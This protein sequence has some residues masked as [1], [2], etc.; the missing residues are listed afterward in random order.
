M[1]PPS[2]PAKDYYGILG[3]KADSTQEEIRSAYHRLAKEHHPDATG[4]TDSEDKFKEIAEA[5]EVLS[6]PGKRS[7]YDNSRAFGGGLNVVFGDILGFMFGKEGGFRRSQQPR[8]I[9]IRL[10][11]PLSEAYSGSRRNVSFERTVHCTACG[12]SGMIPTSSS[13]N[14]C[15]S[16][17]GTG[18]RYGVGRVPCQACG[19]TGKSGMAICKQC[20]WK[21]SIKETGTIA[22]AIPPRVRMG[23]VIRVDGEGHLDSTGTRGFV[24]VEI[25][26]PAR[27]GGF[28]VD[29]MGNLGCVVA[30]P[31]DVALSDGEEDISVLGSSDVKVKLDGKRHDGSVYSFPGM[32]MGGADLLVKVVYILPENMG[33]EDRKAVS[34]I[35]KK[36]ARPNN[37]A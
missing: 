24:D 9:H 32:G 6:D 15:P 29:P 28:S 7:G 27:E 10:S 11:V 14:K 21:G 23:S 22:V 34:A 19:G 18:C 4:D 12:G 8:N 25:L 33:G 1:A 2:T 26:Y 31:W 36:Y 20:N 30:V 3:V 16:C 5:Y 17:H 35:L 13:D 37:T